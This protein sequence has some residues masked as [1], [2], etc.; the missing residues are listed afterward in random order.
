MTKLDS[1]VTPPFSPDPPTPENGENSPFGAGGA[2]G[3]YEAAREFFGTWGLQCAEDDGRR[4][5]VR[6]EAIE[7][8]AALLR[9]RALQAIETTARLA[10]EAT[11]DDRELLRRAVGVVS[12][13]QRLEGEVRA[14]LDAY[15]GAGAALEFGPC[16]HVAAGWRSSVPWTKEPHACGKRLAEEDDPPGAPLVFCALRCGHRGPCGAVGQ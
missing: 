10:G 11:S 16:T 3:E 9:R 6:E 12:D 13:L 4:S 7:S 14:V 15:A 8:L 2:A 1:R 5:I